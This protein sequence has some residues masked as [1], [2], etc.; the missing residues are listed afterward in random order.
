MNATKMNSEVS[1]DL[2]TVQDFPESDVVI[3]DGKCVFCTR[4]VKNLRWFDGKNRLAFISLHDPYVTEQFPDLTH[5]QMMEQMYVVS[6]SSG[7]KFGGAA[8]IR[9]LSTRLPRLWILA[10]VM[11]IP[12]TMPIWQWAYQQ[13]AKRR[14]KIANR[15]GDACDEDGACKVHFDK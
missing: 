13:V 6:R 2:P 4:Q 5:D 9:Y 14:Y 3:F 7:K 1:H 15:D 10:P 8:A 11:H 12:F